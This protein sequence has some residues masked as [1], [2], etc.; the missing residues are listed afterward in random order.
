[1]ANVGSARRFVREQLAGHAPAAVVDD[2]ALVTSELVT[3]AF[4]HGSPEPVGLRVAVNAGSAAVTVT[5]RGD[6]ERIPAVD[7]WATAT[8][9][10]LSGRGLGIVR[11]IADD[12]DVQ[13]SSGSVTIT[14]H[15]RFG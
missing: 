15:R 10:Q 12:I 1:M 11:A 5:S 4:E 2:L 9:E 7:Q 6:G 8:S 14:V 13:R 3:N